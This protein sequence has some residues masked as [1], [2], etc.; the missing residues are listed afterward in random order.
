LSSGSV[1]FQLHYP[2]ALSEFNRFSI[3]T[4]LLPPRPLLAQQLPQR[5]FAPLP[6]VSACALALLAAVCALILL[7]IFA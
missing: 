4:K 2:Q 5:A 7:A 3:V 6:L 1:N